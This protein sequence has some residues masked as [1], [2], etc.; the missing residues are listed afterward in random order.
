MRALLVIACCVG[1]LVA[2]PASAFVDRLDHGRRWLHLVGYAASLVVF[3]TLLL[4]LA[5]LSG[6]LSALRIGVSGAILIAIVAVA[7]TL[8]KSWVLRALVRRRRG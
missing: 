4:A 3:C 1:L 8:G 5:F 6:M 2:L 7:L